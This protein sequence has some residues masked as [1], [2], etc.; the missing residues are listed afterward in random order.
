LVEYANSVAAATG[1]F[2]AEGTVMALAS[3][4]AV[5]FSRTAP[6]SCVVPWRW[7]GFALVGMLFALAGA[8]AQS[9]E[10]LPLL[11]IASTASVLWGYAM[12]RGA[13]AAAGRSD[14]SRGAFLL[15]GAGIAAGVGAAAATHA[16]V[17]IFLP[18][19]LILAGGAAATAWAL[20]S[21]IRV[22]DASGARIVAGAAAVLALLFA[23]SAIVTI[24]LA[25]RGEEAIPLYW[26]DDSIAG[27]LL[28]LIVALGTMV[29]LA[30][31]VRLD[32]EARNRALNEAREHLE[33]IARIDPLTQLY[34]RYAF[35]ALVDALRDRGVGGGSIVIVDVD[36][37]K[38]IND[39]YGHLVGDRALQ[40]VA[41]RLRACVRADDYVFRWGG[42][43]FVAL[44]FGATLEAA[45][46]RMERLEAMALED[47]N[48]GPVP[49][50]V[51]WGVAA[52][53]PEKNI[54]I[55]LRSADEHL[56]R[57]KRL[58]SPKPGDPDGETR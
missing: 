55:A 54:E 50:A 47:V 12:W 28:E 34:N 58:G 18:P 37:L 25:L 42:D 49:I 30:D 2:I 15:W 32:L 11:A 7:A 52:F 40:V 48:G 20:R 53:D 33:A 8:L 38:A 22:A 51:S 14:P 43:E 4:V 13:D 26:Y 17:R 3:L 10:R 29:A 45:R 24:L 44:L 21:Q 5:V 19:E 1:L 56:Y 46:A 57:T 16:F 31:A 6:V 9:Q 23:R 36:G 41:E 39:R 27:A 35:Y